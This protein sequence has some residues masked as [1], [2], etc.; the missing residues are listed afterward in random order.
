MAAR[1]V[2]VGRSDEL[3]RL[4]EA[5]QQA[6]LGSGSLVLVAGDAGVGKTRL[7]EHVAGASGALVLW[8]RAR[9][10][11]ATPYGPVVSALRSLLR[12]DAQGLDDFG[13]LRDQLALILPELG[14]PAPESDRPTLLEAVRAALAH[15]AREETAV[16]VLDDLQ[17]SDEATLEL[18]PALA[19]SVNDL[20][21]LIVAAYRSDGLPRDHPLRRVRHELR[22]SGRLTEVTIP[23]LTP[24]ETADLL[25]HLLE[26]PPAPS[27]VRAICD[28]TQGVTF[29]V[30][31]LAQALL[32]T[33]AL[34]AGRRG[35]ELARG[36]E[37]PVPDT[38]RDAV[39]IG[40]ADLSPEGRAAADVAAVAGEEFDLALVAGTSSP[41]GLAELL[42][43]ELVT[44]AASGRGAF[45]HA[46]AREALYADVPWIER[47]R[48]H[49]RLA[50]ALEEGEGAS[51]E[52]AGHWLAAR[53]ETRARAWL[54]EAAQV[55]RR[56]HA[57]RDVARALRQALELWPAA[58][59]PDLRIEVLESYAQSAGLSGDLTEAARAWREICAGWAEHGNRIACA[60]AQR[61]LAAVHEL[62]AD[63]GAAFAARNAAA[64]A[65]A[66]EG[67]L[68]EAAVERLALANYLRASANYSASIDLARTATT[69]AERAGRLDLRLRALGVQGVAQAK[70]GDYERGLATVRGGLAQALEHDHVEV[71]AELYQ[72]LSMVL[73]DGGDYR[74]ANEML[75][76]ALTLCP[77]GAEDTHVA[78]I[79]CLAYVLRE[80]GQ[81]DE[82]LRLSRDLIDSGT[83]VWLAEGL[84]GSIHGFQGRLS[85]ARRLLT[86]SLATALRLGHFNGVVDATAA[87]ARVDAAEDAVEAAADGCRSL[88]RRWRSSEDHHYAI[89][90]LRFGAFFSASR[91]DL[92]DAHRYAESLT[93]IASETGHPDA[94]AALAHAIGELALAN[95]DPDSAA[96]QLSRAVAV[97]RDLDLPFARAE[98][99]LRAGVALA[100][101]GEREP[102][103][104]LL[105]DAYRTARKL[106]ARP[107]ATE[108]TREVAA[109]GASVAERLGPR[110]AAH[111][112]GPGLTRRE[113]EVVRLVAVGRT[114]REIATE[115]FLSPRT[116]DMH[117]RNLLR[118]LDCRSRVEAAHRAGELDL[119]A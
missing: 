14:Q 42:R 38:V 91:G 68:A 39:L 114:N 32:L 36:G 66:E 65:F 73:Y 67:C 54:V 29:F 25:T 8:G 117:V 28:R 7:V 48:L 13:P 64:E 74:E 62:R 15:V 82:A 60:Q 43:R 58:E 101:A 100:A 76:Q 20:R 115:L 89:K 80:R 116:V 30:E 24:S 85:S 40:V 52:V 55:S 112:D 70:G 90:G 9:Q 3:S 59:A 83:A 84:V 44:E 106:G 31:E 97:H 26:Q 93:E 61:R 92:Q 49:V 77:T 57:H 19:E 47:H 99:E 2:L 34:V 1:S 79:T 69:D 33:N 35:L 107:L 6:R 109:I 45:R 102:A 103:L 50:E 41:A 22:R 46:L 21:L 27:L 105:A 37:V 5:L 18:L 51:I 108:A 110:A 87:L 88:L 10:G 72:R 75:D 71:S 81:W 17:W 119:L 12:V 111:A 98:I 104:D 23:P 86:S 11:A 113:L 63:R 118:K 95:G 56:V 94:I 4:E 53:E 78:C 16:V 96:E